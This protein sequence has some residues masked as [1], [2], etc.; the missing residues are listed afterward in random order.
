M[1]STLG[2]EA[3]A[4]HEGWMHYRGRLRAAVPHAG[5]LPDLRP[6]PGARH[7]PRLAQ[8]SRPQG[9]ALR[10][11][12][13]A[14]D[15]DPVRLQGAGACRTSTARARSRGST[16]STLIE[17]FGTLWFI[18]LLPIFF[19]VIKLDAARAVAGRSGSSAPRSKSPHIDTGWTVIDEFA[20]PLRLFLHRLHLRAAHL[21]ARRAR[22]GTSRCNGVAGAARSGRLVNGT[23]C[24]AATPAARSSRSRSGLLGAAAVVAV[25][26]LM[27]RSDLFEPLR[28][29]GEQFDRHLSRLLPAD[30]GDPHRCCS[31][32]ASITDLGTISLIVTAA[33]VIGALCCYWAVRDTRLG[34]LFER[35]GLFWLARPPQAAPALQPAE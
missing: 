18:Y 22:A 32:P 10:L 13:R 6:V 4:G 34:F 26:A 16:C 8:L 9:R 5:L 19:V 2:V 21:R 20:A 27:A 11:F 31:R 28:Y 12:L 35:P 25:A 7:R 29:C 3:A 15:D 33:G 17:P 14:V 24:I 30:G 23:W 1:H